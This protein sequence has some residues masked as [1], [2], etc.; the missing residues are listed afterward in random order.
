LGSTTDGLLGLI[1][2]HVDGDTFSAENDFNRSAMI[3]HQMADVFFSQICSPGFL[4]PSTA[5]LEIDDTCARIDVPIEANPIMGIIAGRLFKMTSSYEMVGTASSG[6]STTLV[7]A[8]ISQANGFWIDAWVIF[9]GGANIGEARQVTGSIASSGSIQWASALSN[10]VV[11]GDTYV[12]TFYHIQ[13]KT[14][15]VLNYVF[16]RPTSRTARDGI[17]SW[18]ANTTGTKT[19]GDLLCST[20]TLDGS[21]VVTVS[22]NLP[23]GHNRTLSAGMGA[24]DEVVLTGLVSDLAASA[25]CSPITRSHDEFALFGPCT[26]V[27]DV[28][29]CIGTITNGWDSSSVVF[30]LTN[31]SAY[32][33]DINYTLTRKGQ[34]RRTF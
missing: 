2:D 24:I 34:L 7:D 13:S 14:N 32:E 21:G 4:I 10:P 30:T 33:A 6:S 8:T 26:I 16:A 12:L 18:V 19:T 27:C 15:S 23:A 20:M 3:L 28:V 11:A 22:D 29:D 1:I 5:N 31:N 25:T 9:T 17:V